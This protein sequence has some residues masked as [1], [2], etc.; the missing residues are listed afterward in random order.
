MEFSLIMEVHLGLKRHLLSANYICKLYQPSFLI[1]SKILSR[2]L[3]CILFYFWTDE[4][5]NNSA[6]FFMSTIAV[7]Y[8]VFG[9]SEI[10]WYI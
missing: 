7:D 5:K 3:L 2:S 8:L 4:L 9:K 6:L 1:S 10:N